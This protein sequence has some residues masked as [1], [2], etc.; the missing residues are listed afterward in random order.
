MWKQYS[1]IAHRIQGLQDWVNYLFLDVLFHVH[2]DFREDLMKVVD[3]PTQKLLDE[4][5]DT[6]FYNQLV[7]LYKRCQKL[8]VEK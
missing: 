4:T 7:A 2:D 3:I 1:Y 8:D 6:K 5:K